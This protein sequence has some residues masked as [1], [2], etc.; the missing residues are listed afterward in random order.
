MENVEKTLLLLQSIDAK[1]QSAL[2][3]AI[4]AGL[5]SIV[6]SF[7]SYRSQRK[8]IELNNHL[9]HES[10]MLRELRSDLS[11]KHAQYLNNCL[12]S[13]ITLK[14]QSQYIT[15][16]IFDKYGDINLASSE[17]FASY[18]TFEVNLCM[19]NKAKEMSDIE[20][21]KISNL[22]SEARASWVKIFGLFSRIESFS[23]EEA[24]SIKKINIE[25]GKEWWVWIG[26][27]EQL[28]N[29]FYLASSLVVTEKPNN[30]SKKDA[31]TT[32]AS[33]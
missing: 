11:E 26:H 7:I 18:C 16:E 10:Q 21:K 23:T 9:A 29:Q 4:I 5:F 13:L 33:S 27:L 19:L 20:F 1:V 6:S 12:E 22:L 31:Q 14:H 17:V 3:G 25:I 32:R 15:S 2:V 24:D 8:T 30:S 28:T